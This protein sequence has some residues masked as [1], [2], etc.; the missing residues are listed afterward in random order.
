MKGIVFAIFI[1]LFFVATA[2]AEEKLS[3]RWLLFWT[4]DRFNV[5]YDTQ[6]M[7]H[8]KESGDASVTIWTK[9]IFNELSANPYKD[10]LSLYKLNCSKGRAKLEK[11]IIHL[12]NGEEKI[13]PAG[14]DGR[15][16]SPESLEEALYDKHCL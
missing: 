11:Q 7:V 13:I 6:N 2:N 8:K 5:Y 15:P 3:D 1:G 14:G 10:I 12:K 16:I 4:S 9:G